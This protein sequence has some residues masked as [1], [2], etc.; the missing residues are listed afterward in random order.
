MCSSDRLLW[1][2][3]SP[4]RQ[5]VKLTSDAMV[6][7]QRRQLAQ[8]VDEFDAVVE[9]VDQLAALFQQSCRL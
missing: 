2:A 7:A 8:L 1:P 4:A 6:S 9:E 3:Y 5:T